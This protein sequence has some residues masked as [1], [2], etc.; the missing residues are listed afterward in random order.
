MNLLGTKCHRGRKRHILHICFLIHLASISQSSAT[1]PKGLP[2]TNSLFFIILVHE[3]MDL[4]AVNLTK[5]SN[6]EPLLLRYRILWSTNMTHVLGYYSKV[7]SNP[8]KNTDQKTMSVLVARSDACSLGNQTV[9]G[10]ILGSG[11]IISWRLAMK[12]FLRPFSP[13]R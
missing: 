4:H 1:E 11:N 3:I 13:F 8:R 12:P 10:S 9:A 7:F 2:T 6:S 5:N